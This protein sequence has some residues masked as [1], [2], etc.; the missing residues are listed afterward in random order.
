MTTGRI[1]QITR[2]DG[3]SC[4]SGRPA[5]FSRAIDRPSQSS[6]SE[7]RV[8]TNSDVRDNVRPALGPANNRRLSHSGKIYQRSQNGRCLRT[9]SE[10]HQGTIQLFQMSGPSSKWLSPPGP[11]NRRSRRQTP[12]VR[13][14]AVRRD[15]PSLSPR[16]TSARQVVARRGARSSSG[17]RRA[18]ERLADRTV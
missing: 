18:A 13:P 6:E 14:T 10:V 7:R 9:E 17:N 15:A 4:R 1:N 11:W 2:R 3:E 5:A 8:I 12:S 16:A